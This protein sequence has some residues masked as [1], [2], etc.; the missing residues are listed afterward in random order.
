MPFAATTPVP[1]ASGAAFV[2]FRGKPALFVLSDSGNKGA[3]GILDPDS[4]ETLAQGAFGQMDHG[5]DY[6]GVAARNGQ[7]IAVISSG[8][9]AWIYQN[10][11]TFSVQNKLDELGAKISD[12]EEPEKG[13]GK[14]PPKGKGM[15]CEG[16]LFNGNC[17]RNFEGICLDD[18]TRY[19]K[20]PCAGFVASKADGH[21]YCLVE[22]AGKVTTYTADFE[23]SI[24]VGKPGVLADC[25]IG[26]DGTLWVGANILGANTVWR[27]DNWEDPSHARVS[28]IGPLG[29]GNAE[30][31][32]VRGDALYRLSD[33][34]GAPSL[35]SKF[36]CGP[37]TR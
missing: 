35:M 8:L 4:G 27:V 6:E 14:H 37:A 29:I 15:V 10:D 34:D 22:H 23:R 31:L 11:E 5:D 7:L 32:A 12:A 3:Y 2:Q 1:E 28:E 36:R 13:H 9:T 33:T 25:A 24:A 26:E 16:A 20:G 18:R 30:V 17:G 19:T 21:L